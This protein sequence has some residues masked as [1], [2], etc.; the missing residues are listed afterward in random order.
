MNGETLSLSAFSAM[1]PDEEAARQWFE[2]ARWPNGPE[3]PHCGKVGHAWWV[4][5]VRRWSCGGCT[6][7]LQWDDL[8]RRGRLVASAEA[9]LGS[10]G[11][12]GRA[13]FEETDRNAVRLEAG[14]VDHKVVG[15]STLGG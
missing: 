10:S 9:L 13:F 3:C 2:R 14:A 5:T 7:Q 4:R 15:Q 1:F 12:S 6:K 8:D 11:A